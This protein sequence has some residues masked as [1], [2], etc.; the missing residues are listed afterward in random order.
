LVALW[1]PSSPLL[2]TIPPHKMGNKLWTLC[3][4]LGVL[5]CSL[6]VSAQGKAG[7]NQIL[8]HL[9]NWQTS[10]GS[11][12]SANG[13]TAESTAHA[14]LLSSLYGLNSKLNSVEANKFLAT[15]ENKDSGY[16]PSAGAASDV[17][18]VRNVL[19]ATARLN[20]KPA[21]PA[22]TAAFLKSLVDKSTG[23][24]APR[25]G[26]KGTIHATAAALQSLEILGE[27]KQ[28]WVHDL[29]PSIKEYLK[30]TDATGSFGSDIRSNLDA[31]I[32]ASFVGY[33]LPAPALSK[34]IA[35]LQSPQGLFYTDSSKLATSHQATADAILAL[36]LLDKSGKYVDTVNVNALKT[37]L[38]YIPSDIVSAANAHLALALTKS[39]RDNFV[40]AT[41]AQG[42]SG[43][44]VEGTNYK[45]S[46]TVS[47]KETG[48]VAHGGFDIASS[49]TFFGKDAAKGKLTWNQDTQSYSG[50]ALKTATNFGPF[51]SVYTLST[52][53]PGIG[54]ISFT[55]NDTR[56]IGYGITVSP[57]A[58]IEL[59]G[60]EVRENEQ[61]TVGTDFKFDVA[62]SSQSESKLLSGAFVVTFSVLDSS[63]VLIHQ[64]VLDAAKNTKSISFTYKLTTADI[65][66]G[67][68]SFRVDVA[69]TS[70]A[71]AHTSKTVSYNFAVAMIANN[72][73]FDN[74]A[75]SYKI[76]D[77]VKVSFEPATFPD[78][79]TPTAIRSK[80]AKGHDAAPSRHFFL[81]VRSLQGTLLRSIPATPAQ[82]KYFFDI[83]VAATFD[84]FGV[85]ALTFRYHPASGE[86]VLLQNYDASIG[87]LWED[88]SVLNYTVKGDLSLEV[89]EQPK[90]KDLFY[91][92]DVVFKFRVKDANSGQ[93]VVASGNS[94]ANV[95]LELQHTDGGRT[96]TSVNVPAVGHNAKEHTVA[97]W[98][99]NPNAHK[100]D[101]VLT[102]SVQDAD[103]K[104]IA[105][106]N[107]VQHKV[108]IGGEIKVEPRTLSTSPLDTTTTAF[109]VDLGLFCNNKPLKDAQLHANVVYDGAVLATLPVAHYEGRYTVSWAAPH[110][111]ARSGSYTFSFF[112]EAD[113]TAAAERSKTA[114]KS[115]K[116]GEDEKVE[117]I[118]TVDV[119]HS[120]P[121]VTSLP[122][123]AEFIALIT[124]GSIV[125]WLINKR[126]N[127]K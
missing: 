50:D 60:R 77:T 43:V 23:L 13:N 118:F 81:D 55:V 63:N 28:K 53:I 96:L 54:P 70:G 58:T 10:D 48:G 103:G 114:R 93:Y 1:W 123:K 31:V 39:F 61:V 102:L 119:A 89:A 56:N 42:S 108:T 15:L 109:I 101:G 122:V 110:K 18:S 47:A 14:L 21:N 92:D 127:L 17:D 33:E 30:K 106:K 27:D 87:E 72:I 79:R 52:R 91:G 20:G 74:R 24:F 97:H 113:R 51:E 32:V 12:Y 120:A 7:F 68:L 78:L 57:K 11:F 19:F 29:F 98:S 90:T 22:N 2:P 66:A 35:A 67:K 64:D 41:G 95:F 99:I 86:D 6:W 9:G 84:A 34:A 124:F 126:S 104:K 65:P 80:D 76:G 105:L 59:S 38:R 62:L 75:S 100:G 112:R 46:I 5:T 45:P 8:S 36:Y 125:F 25:V 115:G 107:A 37:A 85:N 121:R 82:T 44:I 3:I 116:A 73:A 49:H 94:P 16:G 71:V 26:E 111:A 117:P 83:P 4:A 88:T 69:P 40:I